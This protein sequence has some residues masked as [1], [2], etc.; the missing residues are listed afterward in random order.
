V[1]RRLFRIAFWLGLLGAIAVAVAKVLSHESND[2]P[3]V[4]RPSGPWPRLDADPT[5]TA[6]PIARAVPDPSTQPPAEPAPATS[7]PWVE[8]VDGACPSTH[9][10]KAKLSSK[11][12][13]VPGMANYERTTPDRCYVDAAAAEADGL[14]AAKR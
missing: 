8:P 2:P 9:P 10:V 3:S 6:P 13:H 12:F 7:P 1:L 14:R 5:T 11:I 4:S